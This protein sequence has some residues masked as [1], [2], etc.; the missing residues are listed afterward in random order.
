[1]MAADVTL[2]DAAALDRLRIEVAQACRVLAAEGL[3]SD[4][5]GHVSVRVGPDRMLIRS[6]SPLDPGLLL[7]RPEDVVL[8]DFDGNPVEE[9]GDRVLPQD[10]L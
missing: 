2:S 9:L 7:S 3:V 10:R 4:I 8:A 1:M 6:R 5:L